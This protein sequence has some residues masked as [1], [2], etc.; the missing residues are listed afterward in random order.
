MLRAPSTVL[1]STGNTAN[2][3]TTST[4]GAKPKPIIDRMNGISATI[5]VA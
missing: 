5:G 4:L 1:Y 3:N 2:K